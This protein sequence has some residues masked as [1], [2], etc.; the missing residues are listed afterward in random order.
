LEH[1]GSILDFVGRVMEVEYFGVKSMMV[2]TMTT[3]SFAGGQEHG[4][5]GPFELAGRGRLYGEFPMLE[6]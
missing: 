2:G 1:A 5:P 6:F 4:A 3:S